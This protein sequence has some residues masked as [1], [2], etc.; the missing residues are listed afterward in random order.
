[1]HFTRCAHND[2]QIS[3]VHRTRLHTFKV[4]LSPSGSSTNSALVPVE[5]QTHATIEI[6]HSKALFQHYISQIYSWFKLVL[7]QS[8]VDTLIHTCFLSQHHHASW[9]NKLAWY[10]LYKYCIHH[11]HSHGRVPFRSMVNNMQELS[12]MKDHIQPKKSQPK[13]SNTVHPVESYAGC[14][15]L[16]L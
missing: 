1:M 5:S 13:K 8:S 3:F 16:H 9:V 10:I 15:T 11:I 12:Q 6:L 7:F 2:L 4:S 14:V